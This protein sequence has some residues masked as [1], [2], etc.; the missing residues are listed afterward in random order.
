MRHVT[1]TGK[2]LYLT[3]GL[4]EEGRE[5]FSISIQSDGSRTLRAICEM[6]NDHLIR[7]V[8]YSLAPDWRPLECFVRLTQNERFFGSAVF[9][10]FADRVE[11]VGMDSDGRKIERTDKVREHV[12]SFGAHP[13]C[14][15]TW[16]AK[17]A[18]LR[19]KGAA[20]VMVPNIALSS[21][22]PNG[23][24]GP[25][26]DFVDLDVEFAGEETITTPAGTF[27]CKHFR[28]RGRRPGKPRPPVE[29]WA[30]SDDFIPVRARWEMLHQTYELVELKR[31]EA[32]P[33][34]TGTTD[35]L[36]RMKA[37]LE[38]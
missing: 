9:R 33:T 19:R 36:A 32:T 7:D 20:K 10:F 28:N 35:S 18:D 27:A 34:K 3:D 17:A 11:C 25:V 24:S 37:Y 31:T 22:L 30:W 38:G 4:G 15:D 12:P 1:Y 29:I 21:P 8:T 14:C 16:H 23:G 2:V 6:D 5:H 13:I 26:T